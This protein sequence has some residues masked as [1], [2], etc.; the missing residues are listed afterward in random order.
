[1]LA[2]SAKPIPTRAVLSKIINSHF[3]NEN[4]VNKISFDVEVHNTGSELIEM[5]YSSLLFQFP[6]FSCNNP[7]IVFN[8]GYL[9]G[10]NVL[11]QLIGNKY[12]MIQYFADGGGWVLDSRREGEKLFSVTMDIHN[13]NKFYLIWNIID[14]AIVD[15]NLNFPVQNSFAGEFNFE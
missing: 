7:K 9:S 5:G 13:L 2:Q 3:F 10:Y 11:T 12:L 14:S 6:Q 8:E 4:G 15:R 1:M